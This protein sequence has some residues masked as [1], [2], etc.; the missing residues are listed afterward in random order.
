MIDVVVRQ[1]V[2]TV[3]QAH[4][5][6][7][8]YMHCVASVAPIE[9]E[10]DDR[11]SALGFRASR[12]AKYNWTAVPVARRRI[13]IMRMAWLAA[14]VHSSGVEGRASVLR[15]DQPAKSDPKPKAGD[16]ILVPVRVGAAG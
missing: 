3:P 6:V 13:T 16:G 15:G 5:P 10:A 2:A 14:M 8:L 9:R 11:A 7:A 1:V 12:V 4:A